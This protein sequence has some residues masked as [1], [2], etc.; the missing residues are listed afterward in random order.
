MARACGSMMVALLVAI[1]AMVMPPTK[2]WAD[3]TAANP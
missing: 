3:V 2:A 1:D